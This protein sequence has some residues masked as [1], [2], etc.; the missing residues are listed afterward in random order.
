M[1]AAVHAGSGLRQVARRW[2]VS[3][4][5]VQ[6]WVGR[7]RGQELDRLDWQD[8][9]SQPHGTRRTPRSVEDLV[10]EVRQQLKDVSDLGEFGAAAIH[11]E[12]MSWAQPAVPSLRTIGRIL[13]RRGALDGRRRVRRPPRPLGWY[14]P[15]VARGQ[16]E[17]DSF[18]II[19]GLAIRRGPHVEILNA[20]SLHGGLVQ[21]WP[22]PIVSAR[23][24]VDAVLEH[25]RAVGLP[26]YAQFDNLTIS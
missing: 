21:S 9:S 11:A 22:M 19:E 1:V 23:A 18:D 20:I 8:R 13:D 5:T 10:L 15:A 2:G 12:L 25:W 14:L 16:A 6:L 17:V 26:A 4:A 24:A 7:A 3:L